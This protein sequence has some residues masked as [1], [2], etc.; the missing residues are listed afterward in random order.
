M[1]AR[2]GIS[3]ALLNWENCC[4]KAAGAD[5]SESIKFEDFRDRTQAEFAEE[6]ER[7]TGRIKELESQL[8][9]TRPK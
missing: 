1:D 4:S 9:N 3:R 5:L 7:L 2:R 8:R 6:I